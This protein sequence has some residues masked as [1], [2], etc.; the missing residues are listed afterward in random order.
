MWEGINRVC[1]F[2]FRSRT[3]D[4]G[5]FTRGD[6]NELLLSADASLMD[7]HTVTRCRELLGTCF[8]GEP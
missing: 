1:C 2:Y 4:S 5:P 3:L 7:L 8:P 6:Y